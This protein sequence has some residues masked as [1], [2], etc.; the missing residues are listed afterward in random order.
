MACPEVE[1]EPELL[2]DDGVDLEPDEWDG[3]DDDCWGVLLTC[4]LTSDLRSQ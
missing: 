1:A 2:E 3:L 4:R